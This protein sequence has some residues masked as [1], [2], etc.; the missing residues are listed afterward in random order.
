[1]GADAGPRT[2]PEAEAPADDALPG[3]GGEHEDAVAQGY[4]QLMQLDS[5]EEEEDG[6]THEQ[7]VD[8]GTGTAVSAREMAE[9]DRMMASVGAANDPAAMQMP[10]A[11]APAPEPVRARVEGS[12]RP[13]KPLT[14]GTGV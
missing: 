11:V 7:Q 2:E 9:L 1:M 10:E 12:T 4:E 5:E 6:P 14:K 13:V 3:G 8:G